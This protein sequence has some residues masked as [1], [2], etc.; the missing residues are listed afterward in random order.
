MLITFTQ[1]TL[2]HKI[3]EQSALSYL[4]R[5]PDFIELLCRPI[6]EG[7]SNIGREVSADRHVDSNPGPNVWLNPA[8]S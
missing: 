5:R 8:H 2:Q 1:F 7:D 4:L 3:L 6:V